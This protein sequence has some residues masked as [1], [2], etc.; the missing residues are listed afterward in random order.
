[1][2]PRPAYRAVAEQMYAAQVDGEHNKVQHLADG[3][4][5]TVLPRPAYQADENVR[6]PWPQGPGSSAP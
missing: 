5:N 2:L 3:E 6:E 1:M 4:S